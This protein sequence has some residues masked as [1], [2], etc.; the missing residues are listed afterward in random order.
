LLF[1]PGE[2]VAAEETGPLVE[3]VELVVVE[4]DA[5]GAVELDAPAGAVELD[6]PAGAVE[7]DAPAGA[8]ELDAPAGAVE[9][10]APA[11]AVELDAPAVGR[12]TGD[13][14][15]DICCM[16]FL[17]A[18]VATLATFSTPVTFTL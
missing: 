3:L 14:T 12:T 10:D 7:L 1:T 4:F 9:F 5:A 17:A 11:G 2:K 18:V 15:D 8:V 6:A 13:A 16:L